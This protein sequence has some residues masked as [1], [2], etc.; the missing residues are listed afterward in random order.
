M[1]EVQGDF[2]ATINNSTE[3]VVIAWSKAGW[4]NV[5][6]KDPVFVPD[7]L[8]RLRL[9]TNAEASSLNTVFKTMGFQL[10]ETDLVDVAAKMASGAITA[11]YQSPAAVAAY[12]LYTNLRY[13]ASI[14]IAPFLGGIVMNKVTWEKINPQYREE[15]LRSTRRIAAELDASMQRTSESALAAMGRSGLVINRL[16]AAQE[17]LWANEVERAMPSLLGSTFDRGI[18]QKIDAIVRQYRSGQP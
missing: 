3:Y 11:V 15:I 1:R 17:Q 10:V 13:M 12:R 8:R 4:V 7:D 5:F 2:E 6:S 16:N 9:A 14:N 18:F